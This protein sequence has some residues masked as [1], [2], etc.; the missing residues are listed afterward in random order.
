MAAAYLPAGRTVHAVKVRD[1]AGTW[2]KRTTGTRDALTARAM[3]AMVHTLDAKRERALLDALL[4]G[5][6]L[7][8]AVAFDAW[9]SVPP[10]RDPRGRVREPSVDAR[11]DAV[12][13]LLDVTDLRALVPDFI[14]SLAGKVSDDTAAHYAAAVR[15]TFARLLGAEHEQLAADDARVVTPTMCTP[16]ALQEAFDGMNELWAG[17]TVRKRGAGVARFVTFARSRGVLDYDPMRDVELPP[18]GK[19]RVHFLETDD[20]ALLADAQAGECRI[21]S[22]LLAG[23]GCEVSV[24]LDLRR[25]DVSVT[26]KLLRAA[27]TKTHNR[28]RVARVADW[29]WPYLAERLSGRLPDARLFAGIRDRWM[30]GDAH[31]AARDALV[32][33]GRTAFAG[34]TMRDARHTW[35][36]RAVRS[37]WPLEAVAR[38]L[39]HKD[40]VLVMKVYGRFQPSTEELHRW[41]QQATQQDET[42]RQERKG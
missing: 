20:A 37:G 17:G 33:K 12:R 26:D 21:L 13:A 35:A 10:T 18:A 38:Q 1:A 36:V 9:R 32:A 15:A 23:T 42:R 4:T 11:V 6:R 34:Y 27:G 31:A 14:T 22:A 8:V 7:T 39:G 41:E 2:R 3:Q 28:D 24:A 30:A 25:R 29:A 5:E 16:A 19:P 40:G